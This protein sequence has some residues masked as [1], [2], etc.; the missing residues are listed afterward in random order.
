M[1]LAALPLTAWFAACGGDT[2]GE[3]ASGGSAGAAT[4]GGG[5]G[6]GGSTGGNGGGE[7]ATCPSGQKQCATGCA[8][9]TDP[10]TGCGADSCTPCSVPH[11]TAACDAQQKCAVG[12]CDAGWGDCNASPID[13]CEA[14]LDADKNHCG[15]CAHD[16]V[17]EVGQGSI[18]QAGKCQINCC[19]PDPWM[20]DCDGVAANCCETN[21]NTDPANCGL[22]GKVCA[23]GESC[24]SGKCQ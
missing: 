9:T 19:G 15:S 20:M 14:D 23:S 11:A 2:A 17:A 16:C 7:A 24:V 13:G 6:A 21:T 5:S 8:P 22:C 4:G 1:L 18:C 12:T 10:A 3:G